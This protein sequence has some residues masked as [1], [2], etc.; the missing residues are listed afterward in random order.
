MSAFAHELAEPRRAWLLPDHVENSR[1]DNQIR[2]ARAGSF[3]PAGRPILV[4]DDDES[5]RDML[6]GVLA[7]AGYKVSLAADGEAA[8]VAIEAER[9]ALV[10]LDMRMP[11]VDG[12]EF[13]RRLRQRGLHLPILVMTAI[14]DA[15]SS[16]AEIEAVGYLAKP[17][18]V[19]QLLTQVAR[20][21]EAAPN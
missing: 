14:G 12:W 8:L 6:R 1:P 2:A 3:G 7:S 20:H 13:A 10:L 18:E 17:F 19:D 21:H 11:K 15:R 4:V 5:I 9:P 16:A